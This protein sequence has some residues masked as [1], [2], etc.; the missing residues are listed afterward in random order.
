LSAHEEA[1]REEDV[2]AQQPETAQETRF[3][4]PDADAR[5]P[6]G[7]PS[8]PLQGPRQPV[9]L[10]WRVRD[11]SSFRVLARGRR[12]TVGCVEMRTALL[13]SVTEPPR[14]A[15]AVG[16]NVGPAVVRNRVRRRLRA[17][18]VEHRSLLEPGRGYLLRAQS[19]AAEASYREL[20]DAVR[21]LLG[22]QGR[23]QAK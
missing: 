5:G 23:E 7:H 21:E 15:Y 19:D 22:R 6:G 20:A 2:P 13:G 16:R 18:V 12:S 11:R 9:G 4:H 1:M 10:I 17:A 8:P 3:P 14:A